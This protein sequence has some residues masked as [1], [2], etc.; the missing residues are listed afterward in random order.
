METLQIYWHEKK[1]VYSCDFH[2][3][4][5]LRLATCG[6]DNSIRLWDVSEHGDCKV[7]Y[8]A[9]LCRHIRAV[10]CVRWSPD[11]NTLASAGDG[12]CVM[13][14]VRSNTPPVFTS[15]GVEEDLE[16]WQVQ[17]M[18]RVQENEDL[19]DLCWSPDGRYLL[20]GGSENAAHVFDL[21]VSGNNKLIKSL[22]EHRHYVQ[23]VAWDPLDRWICTQSA[24]RTL[25]LWAIQDKDIRN[26]VTRRSFVAV[27]RLNK[28]D[29]DSCFEDESLVTF[30]RRP[31]FTPDGQTLLAPAG[32]YQEEKV[33]LLL[34]RETQF[35]SFDGC[36]TGHKKP[37]IAIRCCPWM[38]KIEGKEVS[39]FAVGNRQ[40]VLIYD[41]ATCTPIASLG[42]LHYGMVTDLSWSC[43]GSTLVIASQD[44][45]CTVV[46]FSA[47]EL[48]EI[49]TVEEQ[50]AHIHRQR[51]AQIFA[52]I[53][54]LVVEKQPSKENF[55]NEF[56]SP[57]QVMQEQRTCVKEQPSS[58]KRLAPTLLS[59]SSNQQQ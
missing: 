57:K 52:D 32:I 56:S 8:V 58:K 35:A 59:N 41:S 22:K 29:G 1:P 45:F 33:V 26:G 55:N 9:S 31:V 43:D 46:R 50:I 30:F 48:G 18:L 2:P 20:V 21:S 23:G 24:D 14:W 54:E 6:G 36:M 7:K 15:E 39:I 10:N 13:L 16:Y 27:Q 51:A 3:T 47:G 53:K 5:A 25:R 17:Q 37:P 49:M 42:N 4:Q 40:A 34:Q 12:G 28:L 19:F 44:G 11:G 38:F